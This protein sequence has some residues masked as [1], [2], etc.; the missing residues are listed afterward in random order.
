MKEFLQKLRKRVVIGIVGGSDMVKQVEQMGGEDGGKRQQ[1]G[2]GIVQLMIL[3]SVIQHCGFLTFLYSLVFLYFSI[4]TQ[5]YD[6]V[7]PE[8]GLI[9][10]KDGKEIGRQVQCRHSVGV[11]LYNVHGMHVCGHI[12]SA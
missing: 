10:F 12:S 7:F 11:C 3:F 1:Q 8:N 6:Y 9:A 4:V 2:G 5:L